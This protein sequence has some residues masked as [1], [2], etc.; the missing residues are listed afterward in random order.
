MLIYS[1]LLSNIPH[2][3]FNSVFLVKKKLQNI[4]LYS[5]LY[6]YS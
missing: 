1:A 6:S 5:Y 4:F 3:S 2:Y